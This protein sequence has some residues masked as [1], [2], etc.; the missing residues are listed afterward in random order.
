MNRR[1]SGLLA[2]ILLASIGAS[3]AQLKGTVTDPSGAPIGGAQVSVVDRVGV[4]LQTVTAAT[5]SFDIKAPDAPVADVRLVIT[6]P[7]FRTEEIALDRAVSPLSVKMALAPVIDSVKV[8]G[9][10]IDVAASQQGGSVNIIPREEIRQSNQPMAV[11][12]MRYLPGMVFSQTG[13]TGGVAGLYIRGGYPDFNLVEIDGVPVNAF[14]GNFD[15]AHVATE[16]LDRVEVIRGPQSSLYGPYANSGVVNFVTRDPGAPLNFD[17][18]AEG[19]TYHERRFGIS[20]GGQWLGFGVAASASRMDDDGPVVN[21]GYRNENL[22]LNLTRRFGGQS[23]TLHGDFDSNSVGEPGPWGSNPLGI[24]TGIDTVSRSKNNFGDYLLHY[25][26]DL[27]GRVRE[28]V[29]G[30][31][32]MNNNGYN[33]PYG[34][35][36]NKDIRAQGESRTIIAATRHYVAAIGV[37]EALEQVRNTY[38]TDAYFS[39]FPIR[40]NDTAF[41]IEN[42]FEIGGHLFLN[43]GLRGEL[44]RTGAI[45]TDGYTRPLFPAQTVASANPKLAAAYV[46][47]A[48]R[49]HTS[50]GTGIRPP[51]GYDL[52]FTDNPAL[53]PERTRS[54]DAGIERKFLH[55]R[56]SLDATYFYNR[57]YDLIV[58]LGGSLTRLSH[59]QSDNIANSRA[60]GAEF[61]A[62]L[63]PARWIFVTGSYTRLNTDILSLNGA[64]NQAP[65]PFSVGQALLRRPGDSGTVT[66]SFS[67]GKFSGGVTGYF[68]GSVLDVEPSY[69]ASAGLFQN[70]GYANV[71]VNL[72]YAV[73]HGVTAYGNL[74]NAL[75]RYYEEVYGFPSP[76]L[77]FVAG[78]KWSFSGAK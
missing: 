33:S 63:R 16:S 52:A 30:T 24:F 27:S 54:F 32:F 65:T 17:V 6:C 25:Q 68:R 55:N 36:S 78:M 31:F 40:R 15:F 10:A 35:S 14:G 8:V 69:G 21:S 47:G 4:Q 61:S 44:I 62:Q 51:G 74:R 1:C 29:Y 67:R 66:A 7:G 53:K 18:L 72:N 70:P 57:F 12:L 45:P 39:T 43:A 20:G 11:D 22:M 77:N 37:S 34:F 38:I 48:T 9:S 56:L 50:F 58:I 76:R 5:G 73:G 71:G 23:L 3:A 13:F 59:Y 64:S 41:Y 60:Q 19:G 2:A 46:Q 28:E 26:A 42:R 49:L 75:N